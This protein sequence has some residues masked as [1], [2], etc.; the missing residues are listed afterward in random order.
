MIKSAFSVIILLSCIALL[1]ISCK[2]SEEKTCSNASFIDERDGEVYCTT[3]IGTQTWMAENLRYESDSSYQ[4]PL[5][6]NTVQIDYGRLYLFGAAQNACP[7]GW[8]LPT[9]AEWKTL[10]QFIGLNPL[11]LDHIN[12]RG[13]QEGASLKAQNGWKSNQDTTVIGTDDYGFKAIPSGERNPSYG[14]FFNLG[15]NASF[16]TATELDSTGGAWMRD[17]SFEKGSIVRLYFSQNMA[18]ACRC[19]KD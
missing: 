12:E 11:I 3:I 19:V 13:Q 15:T 14:P 10:E 9:D 8:H 1:Q 6:P 4:N 5:N 18:Y 7:K 16:W 17:L 2:K